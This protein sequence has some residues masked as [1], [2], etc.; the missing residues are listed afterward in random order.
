MISGSSSVS[1][2]GFERSGNRHEMIDEH[3]GGKPNM[4][5]PANDPEVIAPGDDGQSAAARARRPYAKPVL[6]PLGDIR[7]VTMAGSL[8]MGESGNTKKRKP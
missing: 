2:C 5:D 1:S 4:S 8:G 6:E 3:G 7:D